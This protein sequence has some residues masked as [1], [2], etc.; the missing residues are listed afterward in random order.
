VQY[1][2]EIL[3]LIDLASAIGQYGNTP[4]D[5]V[6]VLVHSVGSRMV[7]IV[8][9]SIID[10]TEAD[11]DRRDAE[12]IVMGTAVIDNRVTSVIDTAS[13]IESMY[14]NDLLELPLDESLSLA[15]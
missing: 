14:S 9:D 6:S 1:R 13:L 4:G 2:N 10:I 7:G 11:L 12:G 5:S 8:V 15:V 3:P